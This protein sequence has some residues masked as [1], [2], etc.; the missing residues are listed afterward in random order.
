MLCKTYAARRANISSN[1]VLFLR[2]IRSTANMDVELEFLLLDY[3]EVLLV[4]AIQMCAKPISK[5]SYGS[6]LSGRYLPGRAV[7]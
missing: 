1:V 5:T 2:E 3:C 6:S 7:I 4:K